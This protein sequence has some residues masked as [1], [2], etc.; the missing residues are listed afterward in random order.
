MALPRSHL[1]V[2]LALADGDR[3]GY[4]I[5]RSAEENGD[6]LGPGA[7]YT[8]LGRLLDAA[9]IEELDERP[10]PDLD[11]SRRRYYRITRTGRAA[12]VEELAGLQSVLDR[13]TAAGVWSPGP[14]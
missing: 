6:R 3:H 5:M 14:A 2:L 13:A 10:A 7:L 9:L 12:L 11:D 4:A 1:Q 8:A